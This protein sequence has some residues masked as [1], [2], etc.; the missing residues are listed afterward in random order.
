MKEY[1]I[2]VNFEENE[3]DTEFNK[4]VQNDYNSIKLNFEF[5]KEYDKALFEM[6]YP[7][8]NTCQL[9]IKDNSFNLNNIEI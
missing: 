9:L 5:D 7:S 3:I 2:I 8:G 6:K 1:T 4:L